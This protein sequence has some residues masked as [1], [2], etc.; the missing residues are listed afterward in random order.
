[1]NE[2]LLRALLKARA[3]RVPCALVTVAATAGSVPREAGA[4][5]LVRADGTTLGTI[6]GGKFEAL[7]IAESTAALRRKVPVLKTYPLHEGDANS[8]GAIC[9]GEVT[10]L[11]EPQTLTEALF[12]VGAG[13]CA[14]AIAEL[15]RGCGW[16]VTVIDD[17]VELLDDFPAH[18]RISNRPPA[19]VISSRLWQNDEA[20]V[21]VSRNYEIDRDALGAALRLG[22]MAYIGMIGSRRKVRR[23]FDQLRAEGISEELLGRVFA[24]MGLDV[25]ADSPAEI[26]VSLFC[27]VLQVMRGRPGGHLRGKMD[28]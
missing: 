24:P 7:V 20:L 21:I 11:I 22:G 18:Q 23:V 3:E 17:R 15:A 6:G 4:K 25:G 9:G 12:L 8:F 1:M 5:L 28:Q 13:H 26:A 10:V 19:E 14:R 2:E 27:E 16:H